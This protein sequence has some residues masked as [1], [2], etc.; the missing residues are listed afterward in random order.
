MAQK[1]RGVF[2]VL[3]SDVLYFI[4]FDFL[5]PNRSYIM[6]MYTETVLNSLLFPNDI[7]I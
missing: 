4:T 7:F 3:F 1:M 5:L 2:Y 6:K